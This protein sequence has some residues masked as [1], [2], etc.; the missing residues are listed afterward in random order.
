Q[1]F[2]G[3]QVSLGYTASTVHWLSAAPCPLP[4]HIWPLHAR[5]TTRAAFAARARQD[6][7]TFLACR[8]RELRPGGQLVVMAGLMDAAGPSGPAQ[9]AP[10]SASLADVFYRQ[11]QER[12]A[13][14]PARV[15]SHWH[16][17]LLRAA[18]PLTA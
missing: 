16:I 7:Q 3:G 8:A 13:A 11:V 18:R 10:G 1:V 6:W 15:V 2:P 12:I 14:E 5:G 9:H 4:G 17:L